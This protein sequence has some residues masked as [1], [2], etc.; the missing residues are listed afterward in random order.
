MV[1]VTG[2]LV[3]GLSLLLL[4]LPLLTLLLW[5]AVLALVS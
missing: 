5:A 4:L 3:A 2:E 1:L